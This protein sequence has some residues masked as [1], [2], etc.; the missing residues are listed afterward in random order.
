MKFLV[1]FFLETTLLLIYGPI[2]GIL[3]YIFPLN[4][5]NPKPTQRHPI[6]IV[7][8]W[9]TQNPFYY[10]VKRFLEKNGYQ[11]YMTNFGWQ[12]GDLNEMA[13][14]L[15]DYFEQNSLN[16]ATLVGFSEGAII[17]LIYLQNLSGW[18]R[19]KRFIS[20]GGPF[21]GTP[22]SIL[23]FWSVAVKQMA[24]GSKLL[25]SLISKLQNQKMIVCISAKLDEIVP[26]WSSGIPQTKQEIV[27]VF[28]HARVQGF[29]QK[30]CELIAN[31]AR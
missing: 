24:P 4:G 2:S 22:L 15:A 13:K 21:K 12:L 1:D 10:L 16:K 6:V 28:G 19:V 31:Y 14:R 8:G 17:S 29:S 5:I 30:T 7:H 25:A 18:N 3:G 20:I 27:E 11:V 23:G 9:M 26:R